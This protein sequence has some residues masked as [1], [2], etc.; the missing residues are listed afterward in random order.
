MTAIGEYNTDDPSPEAG[1]SLL[2]YKK[3]FA[4][5]NG[6]ATTRSD[7]FAV[8]RNGKV[9][10]NISA[11]DV[12]SQTS[13]AVLQVN[14]NTKTQGFVANFKIGNTIVADDYT[15]V[16]NGNVT[17]PVSNAASK[18]RIVNLCSDGSLRTITGSMRDSGAAYPTIN[19]D[20]SVG[21]RCINV[22]SAG[23]GTWWIIA[24]N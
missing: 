7:A 19:L 4:V 1:S 20:T 17:L 3:L 24:R 12:V 18:G 15:V 6:N 23:D 21:Q 16:L 22:Q 9:G 10:V 11:F 5:G 8:L 2:R 13:D 14:G